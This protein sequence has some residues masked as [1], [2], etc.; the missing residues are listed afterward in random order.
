MS[1]LRERLHDLAYTTHPYKHTT[2]GL[3]E[4]IRDMPN[5]YDYSL[6]FYDRYYRPENCIVVVVGDF[7]QAELERLAAE[8]YGGWER[9]ELRSRTSR[10]SRRRPRHARPGSRGRTRRCRS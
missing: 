2:I 1:L 8:Y 9:G 4:D 6:Q 3:L 5:H 7:D 10:R